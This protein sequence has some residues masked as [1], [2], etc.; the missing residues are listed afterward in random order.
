PPVMPPATGIST[1][2]R[3]VLSAKRSRLPSAQPALTEP[4]MA[5][6]D[7]RNLHNAWQAELGILRAGSPRLP[8]RPR[9]MPRAV[10]GLARAART[11]STIVTRATGSAALGNRRGR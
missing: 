3:P 4:P 5:L 9:W 7:G 1:A 10:G 11:A 2:V 6:W 8:R